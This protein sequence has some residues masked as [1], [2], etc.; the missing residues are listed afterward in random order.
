MQSR[1]PTVAAAAAALG[2]ARRVV[3]LT[4]AGVSAESGIPTFR[5][6][7]TG[8]WSRFRAEDLATPEA[9][10]RNPRLV[11]EWYAWRRTLVAGAAPNPAHVAFASPE[12]R[13]PG[14]TPVTQNVD[15][16]HRRAGS[17]RVIELHGDITRTICSRDRRAVASWPDDSAVPPPCPGCGAALRPDVVWFGEPLPRAALEAAAAAA[18]ACDVLLVAGTSLNVFPAA[19]LV[20]IAIES[21]ARV[22]MVDPVLPRIA[23]HPRVLAVEAAAGTA[24]PALLAAAWPG[25][26]A[27]DG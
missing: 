26:P 5:D 3:G 18:A 16:L 24:L 1:Q 9:F 14:F 23:R 15:G 6:A 27:A 8:L 10:A 7:Q 4:G 21:G 11:W 2:A 22:I 13:V 17:R 25:A 20:P 12:A 19:S